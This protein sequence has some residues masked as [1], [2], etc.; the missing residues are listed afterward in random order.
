MTTLIAAPWYLAQEEQIVIKII[1]TNEF[2]DSAFSEEG[3]GGI[4]KLVPDA[5]VNL[6]N[7]G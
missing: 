6:V 1:A 4:I 3:A 5:P 7:D 2:G